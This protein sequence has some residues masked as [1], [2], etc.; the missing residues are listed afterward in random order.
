[1][2]HST[3]NATIIKG[4]FRGNVI[5]AEAEANINV[6][7]L[8]NVDLKDIL[9]DL[10]KI[11]NDPRVTIES[12]EERPQVP[13]SDM[14][15][16]ATKAFQKVIHHNFGDNVPYIPTVGAGGTD[17]RYLRAKGVSAYALEPFDDKAQ[18]QHGNDESISIDGLKN[19]V[20]IYYE[21]LLELCT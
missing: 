3:L 14:D 7:L 13:I 1:M 16:E 17:S 20:K 12:D 4:G 9:A 8:P 21:L 6:R 18:N 10:R 19:S 15:G 2:I 5:P 11:V